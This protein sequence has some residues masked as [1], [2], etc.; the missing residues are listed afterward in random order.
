MSV[1]YQP[2]IWNK[3]KYFY[4][5]VLIIGAI[6]YIFGYLN[7]GPMFLEGKPVDSKILRIRAFGSCAFLMLTVI[8]LI[9]PLARLDKRFLPILYNRRH[10]GVI[11]FTVAFIH[12][13]Q[14]LGWHFSFSSFSQ[15]QSLLGS[16]TDYGQFLG[17][18]FEVFG[19]VALLIMM[20]LAVTSHDFWLSFLAAPMW[21]ALHMMIYVAYTAVVFHVAL[22]ALQGDASLFF[23]I[24]VSLSV[25]SVC[26]LHFWTA[27]KE[28]RVESDHPEKATSSE[29]VVV[30]EVSEIA[31]EQAKIISLKEDER[32]AIFRYDGKLSAVSNACAHQNGPLGEGRIIDCLVTCPWH[33]Y[34]YQPHN[35]QA[36][37]P[38][39]EKIPTYNLKLDGET[40]LLDPIAN[41]PGTE[42]E[43]IVL[44]VQEA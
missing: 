32:V 11:T 18:P 16:N 3:N 17:F 8:L 21:K 4:D 29:W 26:G 12:A 22:G 5:A 9:G 34:Q 13:T 33:G 23:T 27:L 40:I 31:N 28:G 24:L 10:F 1:S 15:Y 39:T 25:L 6:V 20:V 2:V 44:N 7:I 41:A 36:P 14:V 30:G 43:P 42:V 37:A 38:F 35:G 19:I